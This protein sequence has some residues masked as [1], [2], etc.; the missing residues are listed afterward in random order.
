[1]EHNMERIPS[2]NE[3]QSQR[4]AELRA[5]RNQLLQKSDIAINRAE[6]A[7][8]DAGALRAVRQALRDAPNTHATDPAALAA[9][10]NELRQQLIAE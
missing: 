10:L 9:A 4:L 7:G 3:L 2:L 1:M 6:D 5:C 8:A